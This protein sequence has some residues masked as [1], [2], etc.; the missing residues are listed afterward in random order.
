[1]DGLAVAS[2]VADTLSVVIE[3]LALR[4]AFTQESAQWFER[5]AIAG[6]P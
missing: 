5:H 1:M 4:F 6:A 2:L 3:V